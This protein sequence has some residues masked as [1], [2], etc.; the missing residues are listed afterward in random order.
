MKKY[1]FAIFL[2]LIFS[3]IHSQSHTLFGEWKSYLPYN[4]SLNLSETKN[5]IFC[6]SEFSLYSVDKDDFSVEFYDKVNLLHDVQILNHEY[7][8][9]NNQ[10]VIVYKNGNIDILTDEDTYNIPD[11][12]NNISILGQKEINNIYIANENYAYFSFDFGVTQFNLKN[13]E[14]G[15]TCFTDFSVNSIVQ[16]ENLLYMGT[17]EGIYTFDLSHDGN[18]S[19]ILQ[20]TKISDAECKDLVIYDNNTLFL[21]DQK[22]IAI[23]PT[24]ALDTIYKNTE[25]DFLIQFIKASNDYLIIGKMDQDI[26]KSLVEFINKEGEAVATIDCISR[27]KDVILDENGKIWYADEWDKLR[28]S[29]SL[30]E[31]CNSIFI[32]CPHS[33][34]NSDIE[35][36]G[37][38]IFVASGGA[39]KINYTYNNTRNGFYIYKDNKWNNYH[40]W[41]LPIIRDND[42]YN[43]L[44]IAP[45]KIENKVFI[46]TYIGGLLELNLD[47][48]S[49]I[50]HN[51]ETTNFKIDGAQGDYQ[52]ERIA[53][54]QFDSDNNLWL[55]N[56][57]A[58]KPLVVYTKDKQFFNYELKGDSRIGEM[59]IDQNDF[60][61]LKVVNN[62]LTVYHQKDIK[63]PSDNEEISLTSSNS[64]LPSN[65]VNAIKTD[66]D[67]NVWVGTDEGPVVFE[68]ANNIFEGSCYGTRKKTVLEGIAAYVL[69]KVNITSIEVDGANRKWI[70]STSGLYVLSPTGE[71]ELMHFTV[72]NSPIFDNYITAMSYN[73]ESGEMIIGTGKGI[74]SYKTQTLEGERRNDP[75]AFAFPNP[76]SPDYKG[77]I[78]IKGLARDANVKIID[79]NGQLI[80][81]TTALG[82]QAIWDGNDFKGN[83]V[84]SGVYTIFS[85]GTRNFDEPESIAIKVFFIN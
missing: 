72:D 38:K 42:L 79:I 46:G 50:L 16:L 78:A 51:K 17:D 26:N 67:G 30:N 63:V 8:K 21:S 29:N 40:D 82:G 68:C 27:I 47:D 81:E 62:G 71:E 80:N 76:V 36:L 39:N 48:N 32:D 73:G 12:K 11:I 13:F 41:T 19:D 24:N 22:I 3:S 66:L 31:G 44:T 5:K 35:T 34:A 37:D 14:F 23:T 54:M 2:I 85:T 4:S 69:D 56:F 45:S 6:S 75:Y 58:S 49:T 7:D 77:P 84:S 20:W 61:W 70:G 25:D 52:R 28:W 64:N 33:H 65:N 9:Y 43:F 57:L 18:P 59:A 53:D 15:F 74:L 60:I 83:R 55:S 10:L 1:L